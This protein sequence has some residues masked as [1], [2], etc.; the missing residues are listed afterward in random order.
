MGKI[1]DK[2]EANYF[3]DKVFAT[4]EGQ[5]PD[6]YLF[7]IENGHYVL[8]QDYDEIIGEN[9]FED[10][11]NDTFK[12]DEQVKGLNKINFNKIKKIGEDCF[13]KLESD[14]PELEFYFDEDTIRIEQRAFG[15]SF[16]RLNKIGGYNNKSIELS[17]HSGCFTNFEE[18]MQNI[19]E[20]ENV[21][22]YLY[23]AWTKK[24][25]K[26]LMAKIKTGK[27]YKATDDD[28]FE[29]DEKFDKLDP[30]SLSKLSKS[31]IS[32][33][34]IS[35]DMADNLIQSKKA[36]KG[37]KKKE[38]S[39]FTSWDKLGE[40]R[41]AMVDF[42]IDKMVEN[43]FTIKADVKNVK[44]NENKLVLDKDCFEKIK[45]V[46][47]QTG[48][49]DILKLLSEKEIEGKLLKND[50]NNRDKAKEAVKNY[51]KENWE[52]VISKSGIEHILSLDDDELEKLTEGNEETLR[53]IQKKNNIRKKMDDSAL[54]EAKQRVG[55]LIEMSKQN[56]SST[57]GLPAEEWEKMIKSLMIM[58]NEYKHKNKEI[59]IHCKKCIQ[60]IKDA[61]NK[62]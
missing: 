17:L 60:D 9:V 42:V 32:A 37:D 30:E 57:I 49:L 47:A 13:Y 44:I 14:N 7:N 21:N 16:K 52:K 43:N 58:G 5:E 8:N 10:I 28:K 4:K 22:I 33:I 26:L 51:I 36:A 27:I 24:H 62:G 59:A 2:T 29:I 53:A 23:G 45:L 18:I 38:E 31:M 50:K 25:L 54:E 61:L 48:I 11:F 40:T 1:L 55:S 3:K 56:N 35:K 19:K 15:D 34:V 6:Q 12:F 39:A 46:S 41:K 20:F